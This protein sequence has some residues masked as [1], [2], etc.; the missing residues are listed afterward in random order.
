MNTSRVKKELEKTWFALLP[1]RAS[2]LGVFATQPAT[3]HSIF[4]MRALYQI[5]RIW[6]WDSIVGHKASMQSDADTTLCS[7]P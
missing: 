1:D 4:C 6:I 3:F 2:S 5:R 7:E